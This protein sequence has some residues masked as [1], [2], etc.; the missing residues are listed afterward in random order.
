MPLLPSPAYNPPFPFKNAHLQTIYPVLFRRVEG[1]GYERERIETPDD[2]FLDLD[3]VKTGVRRVAILSH[4]LEGDTQRS[5]MRG[6]AR[7]LARQGWDVLAWNYRGC[8]GE[9]NRRLYAYHSGATGDLDL[10]VQH[11]L[12][13]HAYAQ[14]ALV[15]FSLGGN[16]TLKYLGEQGEGLDPRLRAA[17][18]FSVPCD[19]DAGVTHIDR[20]SNWIYRMRFLRDLREKTRRKQALFPGLLDFDSLIRVT[21]IRAFDDACTAPLHGFDD[22]A[23]YYA[24][25]SSLAFIPGIRIPTLLVNAADD[26]VL[27]ETCYPIE[28]T[29]DHPHVYF[30][31]PRHGGHVGFVA[32]HEASAYWSE[33]RAVRFL[34]ETLSA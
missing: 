20:P 25:C 19:L 16:L 12:N 3:W 31:M 29:R 23:D 14:A 27:P 21:T 22:A 34:D 4:G 18:A 24:R 11:A 30:E 26:P 10:V 13:H 9:P 28:A 5:Y 15:G 7:A 6:M 33:Q 2:D 32:S 17:V 8:S 1:M